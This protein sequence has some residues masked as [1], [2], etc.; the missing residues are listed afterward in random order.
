LNSWI[1]CC[2]F[3]V[4]VRPSSRLCNKHHVNNANEVKPARH[5]QRDY[6]QMR[7]A[8]ALHVRLQQVQHL[9][10]A[11]EEQDLVAFRVEALEQLAQCLHLAADVRSSELRESL[12][13]DRPAH[14]CQNLRTESLLGELL[15]ERPFLRVRVQ[16][17]HLQ[18]ERV[19]RDLLQHRQAR[20]DD[21]GRAAG[22]ALLGVVVR[23]QPQDRT[24]SQGA[25]SEL[26]ESSRIPR[27]NR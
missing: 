13:A 7:V 5:H 15:D 17:V 23:A 6:V 27:V 3:E 25:L 12:R 26:S 24:G 8:L 4:G 19:I 16:L 11:T 22:A 21:A 10:A 9:S 18:Q 20:E 2:R 14:P 1:N